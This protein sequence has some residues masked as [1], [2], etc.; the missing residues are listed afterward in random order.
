M[1]IAILG[2]TGWIGSTITAEAKARGHE[3]IAIVRDPAKITAEGISSRKFDLNSSASF[4]DAAKGAD[5]VIAAIGARANG[6][7]ALVAKTA[8][9]LLTSL[10]GTEQRLLWVGGA[11][12]LEVAPGMV[13]VSSPDF[14]A[15]YKDEALAQGEALAV[16]R[17]TKHATQW[18]FISPAAQIYPGPSEDAF[19][20]GGDTFFTNSDGESKIS[21]T[22][23]AKAML[24]EAENAAHVNQRISVAY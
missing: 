12:S 8:E 19:R 20:I 14:P 16:F 3:V 9:R 7:H 24:D 21:V 4:A 2:A 5:V 15:D 22:D 10:A 18:T 11:G 13:L 6:E 23:Y 1:K 17:E